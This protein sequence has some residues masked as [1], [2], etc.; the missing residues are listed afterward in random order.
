M[1][2]KN[3]FF[4]TFFLIL[5]FLLI[6]AEIQKPSVSQNKLDK[7]IISKENKSNTNSQ[8]VEKKSKLF[9]SSELIK[10][11][12]SSEDKT[13]KRNRLSIIPEEDSP[14]SKK[15]NEGKS[16]EKK[17]RK[18]EE[19]K[20]TEKMEISP[21]QEISE[22]SNTTTP[23]E[24][25]QSFTISPEEF[26][27]LAITTTPEEVAEPITTVTPEEAETVATETPIEAAEPVVSVTPKEFTETVT[28]E[29][30]VT[31]KPKKKRIK[32]K[33]KPKKK[34]LPIKVI[35]EVKKA[36]DLKKPRPGFSM[37]DIPTT[38]AEK[39]FIQEQIKAKPEVKAKT[40]PPLNAKLVKDREKIGKVAYLGQTLEP[41]RNFD[42]EETVEMNFE[43]KEIKELL[44]FLEDNLKITF[45][46]DD[47]VGPK[48]A[49]GLKPI[50]GTKITF[51]S[52]IPLTLKQVWELG[53]TF[54]EMAGFSVIPTTI[55]RTYHVTASS[56]KTSANT[57]PLPTFIGTDEGLLPNDDSKIRYVY[58]IENMDIE[59]VSKIIDAM[60]SP[61]SAAL[62][63]LPE[64]RAVIITDISSLIKSIINI[65]Q[66]IDTADTPE[67]LAIIRLK[68]AD[69][70]EIKK[71]Y[72]D[73]IGKDKTGG[74]FPFRP[75]KT[76]TTHYFTEETRVFDEPRSNS[77]IILGTRENIKKIEEFI[78]KYIDKKSDLPYSPLHIYPLKYIDANATAKLLTDLITQFNADPS[79]KE[80]AAF[81]SVRD[82][83]KIFS[84]T[85]KI[86]PE[87]SGNR[88][89]INAD[90]E[91][92]L[93][94]RNTIEKLDVEQP[95]AVIKVL[96]LDVDLNNVK[97][98][99]SQS[100]N[101]KDCCDGTG[102]TDSILGD[103]IN[104]QYAGLNGFITRNTV[105]AS[106]QF[107]SGAERLL[108][109]LIN[110]AN[111]PSTGPGLF[112]TG[113]TLV[114]LGK[115]IFGF[116][117][118]LRILETITRVS[119][120]ANPFLV[121]THKYNAEITVGERRRVISAIVQGQSTENAF[122]NLDANISVIITPQ[123]SYDDMITLKIY[124]NVSQFEEGNEFGPSILQK[125]I[126]SEALVANKEVIALGGLIRDSVSETETKVPI[127]GDIPLFGW[128]FKNKNK[129][130]QRT[131][132]LI[133]ISTEIIK[134]HEP[135]VAQEYTQL[136]LNDVKETFYGMERRVEKRD[137]I[138]RWIFND[139]KEK[140]ISIIDKFTSRQSRYV[141]ASKKEEP[142]LAMKDKNSKEEKNKKKSLLEMVQK[143]E[144]V[145][146]G[147]VA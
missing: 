44:K 26:A 110:L 104:F 98:F 51:K 15:Q 71:L 103:N 13:K 132:L 29:T 30:P 105:G 92:Y 117:G 34:A 93:H 119:V 100:R 127:F 39:K 42:E 111:L 123:I 68:H 95:Q 22:T 2:S 88:L 19:D 130:I 122:Q 131:S 55:D 36:P 118:L 115:D 121:T 101:S 58:F 25:I 11:E 48:R 112:G 46:L 66:K 77:L 52:N 6:K 73:L 145:E 31:E 3:N 47:N 136:Q 135:E 134:A 82:G 140:E 146:Q 45:I 99:G 59:T 96:I 50:A 60:R 114:T 70:T 79:R 64:L 37:A 128:L 143:N 14:T 90:Y 147:L 1:K 91:D 109:N 113:T 10:K 32:E 139:H 41:W 5:S 84:P 80:A 72:Q 83:N 35:K 102:G 57:K 81:G 144:M 56:G 20:N 94:L 69:A 138:H 43:N 27:E 141:A 85:V 125:Q 97:E 116:W 18:E 49:E 28:T 107:V 142:I 89:I 8:E 75:K 23:A 7:S 63:K 53:L 38:E 4:V 126:S 67:T 120:I 9:S 12:N 78:F 21:N 24:P 86:I 33:P 76:P 74:V 108:G 17:S 137:P 65:L 61:S 62:I 54:L 16:K 124:V 133:L 129:S 40:A 87:S 106:N